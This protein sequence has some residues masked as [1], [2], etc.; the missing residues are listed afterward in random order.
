[1]QPIKKELITDDIR[2]FYKKHG[3]IPLKKEYKHAKAARLRFGTWNK[4]IIATGLEP[5]REIFAKKQLAND[6]HIVDSWS[7]KIIDDSLS[8]KKIKHK[9][10]YPYPGNKPFTVDF[11]IREYWVEFFGLTGQLKRYD[12]LKKEK[13]MVARK[14]G[15]KLIKIYPK[16][17]FP[18][19]KL[20]KILA[21]L[22]K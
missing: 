6:G 17:L 1:M 4:A 8:K 19:S 21:F 9:I 13:E 10:N 20:D 14:Y 15:L 2:S 16:D 22:N 5:N 12:Q 3:R 11:K 18:K 7:E